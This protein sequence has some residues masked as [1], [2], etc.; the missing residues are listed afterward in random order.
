MRFERTR[1]ALAA[2]IAT[3]ASTLLP[4]AAAQAQVSERIEI[5]GSSIKRIAKEGALP[6]VTLTSEDIAKTGAQSVTDLIQM[7]PQMQG[8]VPPSSSVNGGGA[9][10]ATAALHSL[11]S[12]YTLVLLDGQ[13]VAPLLLGSVQGGG[14]AVNLESLPLEAVERVEILSDGASA[15][16]GSDAIA[17]VV[18]FILKKNKTDGD[19]F[20][21]YNRPQHPGGRSWNAGITKGFGNLDRDGFNILLSFGHDRQ[22]KLQASQRKF[23]ASGAYFPFSAN[24]QNYIFEQRTGN[25]EP[26]NITFSA[27]PAGSPPGTDPTAYSINPY[28][29]ANGNCGS[30][31]AGPISDPAVLG[32]PGVSCRFNY[33][34]TVQAIP[35]YTRDS[36]IAK[37]TLK[38]GADTTLWGELVLSRFKMTAQFA[39]AAQPLPIGPNSDASAVGL[40]TLYNQYVVPYLTANN[41]SFVDGSGQLGYRS[42]QIGG[43]TDD[44]QTDALHF[45]TGIDGQL[46]GWDYNA[47]LV[48]SHAKFTDTAAGGYTSFDKFNQVVSDGSYDP[49]LGVGTEALRSAVLDNQFQKTRSD[50]NTLHLGAQHDLFDL[51]AGPSVVS[52]GADFTYTRY[53]TQYDDLTLSQS[54][55]STQPNSTDFPVG[56]SFGLV[57]FD[58]SRNNWGLFGEWLVP[59]T[60]G[61]EITAS[62]RY[63]HYSKTHSRYVFSTTPDP[64]TG[65]NPQ[66]ADADLG[67]VFRA[68]TGKLSMRFQPVDTLL[69][70]AAYGTGFKAPNISDI[71]GALAFNGN[72]AGSYGCPFPGSVGCLPGSAQYDLVLGPN[73][74]SGDIGLKPEKSTQWTLGLRFEPMQG[75][76]L[77]LDLWNVKLKDQVLSQGIAEQVA[78]AN[79]QLYAS[80]FINPYQDPAGFTTIAFKQLPFNGGEAEFR[81]VDW[82]FSY[83]FK[84]DAGRVALDWSGTQ[85][86]KQRYNFGTGQPFNTDLGVYGPDQQVVFRTVSTL[87][88]TVETGAFVNTLAWHYRSGYRDQSF[89]EGTDIFLANPDGSLGASV[90]FEGLKVKPYQTFDWQ[91]TWNYDKSLQLTLGIKNLFDKDPPRSLQTGGGGN[92]IGYDGRYTDPLGRQFYVTG[93]YR[94]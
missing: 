56:G 90:A 5:T 44:Y 30:P 66:L 84:F 35:E 53:R 29:A 40:A 67:N 73:G 36:G 38:L 58:A 9:G 41:L 80:L 1:V 6:V 15:L 17:G 39:P 85:M 33:A 23:A 49:V 74:L 28:Y 45:A 26:A 93:R 69:L 71:A 55:Y 2:A 10:V 86:L 68:G 34:A 46:L 88:A 72:T 3:G 65:L 27:V 79:P 89:A 60:K 62:A 57:P 54:G 50:L 37:G 81:G 63:D 19:V 14:F 82:D 31:F 18:N 78:F 51:G 87:S 47:R 22:E 70:R 61:F 21:T 16:Y 76:S 8:F 12:K 59:V 75:L 4:W 43:R 32:G 7:L 91:G 25:T 77:G 92:Q 42:V 20:A 52:L 83:R 11:P 13:R 94:F 48:L 64:A 24:G